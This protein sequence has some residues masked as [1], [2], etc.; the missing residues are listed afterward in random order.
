MQMSTAPVEAFTFDLDGT[1]CRYR[2]STAE[3][4][5]L[6]F[7][8][9]DLDPLFT[10]SAY[11]ASMNRYTDECD[12]MAEL[13]EQCFADLAAENGHSPADGRRVAL[14]YEE[15]R[16]HRNVEPIEGLRQTLNALTDYPMAIVTN[17]PPGTQSEKLAALDIRAEFECVIHA[18]YDTPSKP[19]PTPF[20]DALSR[21]DV[22][23]DRA[24]H[25][26]NSLEADVQGADAAGMRA[27]WLRADG[28][29]PS[30]Q[31]QYVL[32]SLTDLIRTSWE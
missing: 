16:D 12:T 13:R 14:A 31:P 15:R 20:M 29:T 26:G 3:I 25:V 4:L 28:V 6:A 8:C 19:D 2:R 21:L 32:D 23:P 7:E 1:L 24:V 5:A 18:G 22:D 11:R 9:T 27:A 10:A 17:G 30:P